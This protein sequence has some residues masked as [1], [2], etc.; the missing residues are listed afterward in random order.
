[1]SRAS[2]R[3]TFLHTAAGT[4]ATLGFGEWTGLLTISPATANEANVTPDLVRFSPE[5]EP[6]VRL[7]EETPREKCIAAMIEQMRNGLPYRHFLAA[8]YLAAIRAATYHNNGPHGYDHNAYVVHAA[9]QLGLALPAGE[10]LL[11]AFLAL[12]QFKTMQIVY[13]NKRGTRTLSGVLPIAKNA[14]EE[15]HIAMREWES[16]RAERAIVAMSRSLGTSAVL[17][18]LWHYTGRDWGFIGHNA[19]LVANSCRLL[20]TIGWQHAEH[21]LRYVVA[22]LTGW[23]KQ[24]A[25]HPDVLPYWANLKRIES[26]VD[27]LPVDWAESKANEGLTKELLTSI[28]EGK[29]DEACDLALQQLVEGKAKGGA[30]WDAIHLAAGELVLSSKPHAAHRPVNS[31]A[32]CTQTRLPMLCTTPFGPALKP[33][34]GYCCRCKPWRGWACSGRASSGAII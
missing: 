29:S 10:Q 30:V 23:G 5:I 1:M 4:G 14:T 31:S 7:I 12:D 32:R 3:R 11:P 25:E 13:P 16:D 33:T 18:P 27:Q 9:H 34:R 22:A 15:F 20:E 6:I 8:L 19:I 21:V 28:R 24:H 26:A 17:D 2:T